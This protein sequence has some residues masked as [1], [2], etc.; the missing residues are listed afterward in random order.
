M[1]VRS[2]GREEAGSDFAKS[3]EAKE[4]MQGSAV[5]KP[6]RCKENSVDGEI[7]GCVKDVEKAEE[8]TGS[9]TGGGV[10][11]PDF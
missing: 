10:K 1:F 6:D 8:P 4:T 5:E 11:E 3:T 7:G 9:G 2:A